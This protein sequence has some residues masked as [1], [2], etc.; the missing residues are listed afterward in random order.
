[1]TT[2]ESS[3][4]A[5]AEQSPITDL[6]FEV[7]DTLDRG[8]DELLIAIEE[9]ETKVADEQR[10]PDGAEAIGLTY[11]DAQ[12]M[13]G[14]ARGLETRVRRLGE[15]YRED[16]IDARE[17]ASRRAQEPFTGKERAM[18]RV[19][20]TNYGEMLT[21]GAKRLQDMSRDA[22]ARALLG[23][24]AVLLERIRPLFAEQHELKTEHGPLFAGG[25]A[26]VTDA[27]DP[28]GEST[29]DEDDEE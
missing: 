22:E 1:M 21:K 17:E 26:R 8:Y 7:L 4:E 27:E 9:Y 19:A 24:A 2:K 10:Q 13:Q 12:T 15:R 3:P 14:I 20:I 11:R 23:D 28:A 29:E 18:L 16:L 25:V 5:N 6:E